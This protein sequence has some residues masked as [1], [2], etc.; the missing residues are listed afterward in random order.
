M[1]ETI[2]PDLLVQ[3]FDEAFRNS[4]KLPPH[5]RA[6]ESSIRRIEDH[7][8]IRLPQT[9]IALAKMSESFS[10]LFSSFGPNYGDDSHVI[11]E[12]SYWKRRRRTRRLPGNLVIIGGNSMDEDFH[13]LDVSLIEKDGTLDSVRY[14]SPAPIGY[15]NDDI[16]GDEVESVAAFLDSYIMAMQT[17]KRSL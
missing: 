5:P 9:L 10:A 16:Y 3:R 1:S 15:P 2:Q 11:R 7:F 13:C 14:W 4:W 8:E 17:P 12:N 6:T